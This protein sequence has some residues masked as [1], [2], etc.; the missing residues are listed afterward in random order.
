MI[1]PPEGDAAHVSAEAGTEAARAV[2]PNNRRTGP[3]CRTA[4][5]SRSRDCGRAASTKPAQCRLMAAA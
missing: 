4:E 3:Y 2:M 5:L 1:V